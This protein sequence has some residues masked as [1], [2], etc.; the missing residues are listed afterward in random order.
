MALSGR[1]DSELNLLRR[2]LPISLAKT[3]YFVPLYASVFHLDAD[4]NLLQILSLD[5]GWA[6]TARKQANAFIVASFFSSYKTSLTFPTVQAIGEDGTTKWKKTYSNST[7]GNPVAQPLSNDDLVVFA[8][9]SIYY[10][11]NTTGVSRK[12]SISC[13]ARIRIT[14]NKLFYTLPEASF[15]KISLYSLDGKMI[16][17]VKR[18]YSLWENILCVCQDLPEELVS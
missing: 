1:L 12:L 14:D 5:E 16:C 11:S 9:D 18:E 6:N 4:G 13:K 7:N 2:F 15:V 3:S 10:Y 8:S 17:N